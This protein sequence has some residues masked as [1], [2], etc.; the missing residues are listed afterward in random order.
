[1]VKITTYN[2]DKHHDKEKNI[3]VF[4]PTKDNYK[5]KIEDDNKFSFYLKTKNNLKVDNCESSQIDD[6]KYIV[7][8][9]KIELYENGGSEKK[10]IVIQGLKIKKNVDNDEFNKMDNDEF[11]KMFEIYYI[12]LDERVDRNKLMLDEFKKANITKYTKFS[13]IKPSKEEMTNSKIL[14]IKSLW[15]LNGKYPNINDKNDFK[16]IQGCLGCKMSHQKILKQFY[17]NSNH[18]YLIVFE[19]DCILDTN[20]QTKILNTIKD[21]QKNKIQFNIL[22]MSVNIH[23]PEPE[24][25]LLKVSEYLLKLKTGHGNTTHAMIFDINTV[26]NILKYIQNSDNEIDNVYKNIP[27]RYVCNPMMT[28]QR[29]GVSNIGQY[30]E[31]ENKTLGGVFYGDLTKKYN[32]ENLNIYCDKYQIKIDDEIK[33]ELNKKIYKILTENHDI[34]KN[35]KENKI[36]II[37]NPSNVLID[38]KT[39]YILIYDVI[40]NDDIT[41]TNIK[42]SFYTIVNSVDNLENYVSYFYV[43]KKILL[44]RTDDEIKLMLITLKLLKLNNYKIN[45]DTDKFNVLTLP[46]SITRLEQ[47]NS[48]NNTMINNFNIVKGIKYNPGFI[49]CGL[50]YNM[51]ISNASRLN[52]DYVK[53]C[54]DDCKIN[55]YDIINEAIEHLMTSGLSWDLLSCFIVD[56]NDGLQIYEQIELDSQYKLLKINQWSSMV[57]NIYYKSSYR[58]FNEY[59]NNKIDK[60]DVF[61]NTIDRSLKFKDIWVIYPYPVELINSKSE[62]WNDPKNNGYNI[63]EYNKMKE[64]SCKIINNVLNNIA[65]NTIKKEKNNIDIYTILEGGFGN[66]LFMIFNVI[67]LGIKFNKKIKLY[68]DDNYTTQYFKERQTIRKS[69][70]EYKIFKNIKFEKINDDILHNFYKYNEKEYVYNE[71]M[72]EKDK[73]Y[74]INGYFQSYK[75]FWDY[76]EEIKKH[77]FIDQEKINLIKEKL[78]SYG[79]KII[80]I[81]IRLGDYIKLQ[82]F[83]PI[84]PI[85]YYKKALS[86]Y[87]LD[88][89]Q[90]I[91]FS[92][93]ITNAEDKLKP[94]NLSYLIANDLYNNDEEQFYMLCLSD[95]KICSNSSFSLMSCYF[96]EMYNFVDEAEYIFPYKWFGEKGPIYNMDDLMLNYRF[97][98]LNYDEIEI[99]KYDV[100]STLHIKDLERYKSYGKYNKKFLKQSNKFYYISYQKY[101]NIDFNYLDE[102]K[103]PFSKKDV[104]NYIKD[105]VPDYRWGWYYQQLLKL[106][107]FEVYEF[108]HDYILIFDSDI[109]L[110]KNILLFENDKPIL[111][112][113]NTLDGKIHSPYSYSMK[114]I[115]PN[116]NINK[117]DSGICHMMLFNKTLLKNMINEAEQ[118]HNKLFWKICLDSVI[119]YI[120]KNEYNMS[121][122]SEYEIYYNYVKDKNIYIY[123]YDLNYVDVNIK[124]ININEKYYDYIADHHYQSRK[125]NDEKIDNLTE[126]NLELVKCLNIANYNYYFSYVKNLFENY[127]C[128]KIEDRLKIININNNINSYLKMNQ[129][130]FH[131]NYIDYI[132]II[133]KNTFL[134]KNL[135]KNKNYND[136]TKIYHNISGIKN[137]ILILCEDNFDELIL[138]RNYK[139]VSDLDINYDKIIKTKN[140]KDYEN[141]EYIIFNENCINVEKYFNLSISLKKMIEQK[142]TLLQISFPNFENYN[143][144]FINYYDSISNYDIFWIVRLDE[145][146]IEKFIKNNYHVYVNYVYNLIYSTSFKTDLVRYLFLYKFGGCYFDLSI[147]IISDKFINLFEKYD[148][149]SSRDE[150][151][152]LLQNGILYLKNS[153]SALL[154]DFIIE[155]LSGV[156][157]EIL[158]NK[159]DLSLIF[160]QKPSHDAFFFGPTTLFKLYNKYKN[161]LNCKILET[162]P[163]K[164]IKNNELNTKCEIESYAIEPETNEKYLQ[165][166]YIGYYEDLYNKK[167]NSNEHYTNNCTN[168]LYYKSC[169]EIFDKILII[170]LKHRTDRKNH[171]LNEFKKISISKNKIMFIDAIYDINGARGCT[172]SHIKCIEYAI[173]NNLNN[174]LILEDDYMFANDLKNLNKNLLNFLLSKTNWDGILF[175]FSEHGPPVN[176]KTN[177]HNVYKNLW[178]NSTAGYAINKSMFKELLNNYKKT[179]YQDKGPLD[180]YWNNLKLTYD[181][182]VIKQTLGTQIES[183]SDIEKENIK[184]NFNYDDFLY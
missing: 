171:M 69:S 105:Y 10:S 95:I 71:I 117:Y 132:D 178:S 38:S 29:E 147:K 22:Y 101:E 19:D 4:K 153:Q 5:I 97:F 160:L 111:Y 51:I 129:N 143:E 35:Q 60:K 169:F 25:Q 174:V 110:L 47:F 116:I 135:Q 89:Y 157:N 28:Y 70:K 58:Y 107:I 36:T 32:L 54:E 176:L 164:K 11:N 148:F 33:S 183:Y 130:I 2:C 6:K 156:C 23:G 63:N 118:Y 138:N 162:Y 15:K 34:K 103:Y 125:K 94:L 18:K 86:Y 41:K 142:I 8:N 88:N 167:Y 163:E 48:I 165:V 65:T 66:Q 115:F 134:E 102:N 50:S 106:Y 45:L 151:H 144:R 20:L 87:N 78:N 113:R 77:L 124:N 114:Y 99:S 40:K 12:N 145:Y 83:H 81:H 13:G 90:I 150:K 112:K 24:K 131:I 9:K 128:T 166:K 179:L 170:N 93:D 67:S 182:F 161:I 84:A 68:F 79:K 122:L 64:K 109:L 146:L 21:I 139:I 92:D 100:V 159:N 26:K 53:I 27:D 14:N 46:T 127:N 96:N 39:K 136:E 42:N 120:K 57:C 85:E 73:K 173:D 119:D 49:G 121:I 37:F 31:I 137:H 175:N 55:D 184:Y 126:E 76:R 133:T 16:Y 181:W 74:I 108:K 3:M 91:L 43:Y 149:I 7:A 75:Y 104:I 123:K 61:S 72:L 52:L 30:R 17:K 168:N 141:C 154:K 56:L 172:Q 155:I 1:M 152:D 180:F 158:N 62:L 98:V 44:C 140:F 80:S 82:D 59:L 177:L